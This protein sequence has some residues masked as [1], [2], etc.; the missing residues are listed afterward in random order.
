MPITEGGYFVPPGLQEAHEL[1]ELIDD[2]DL[3]L[4][5]AGYPEFNLDSYLEGHLT[6]VLFGAA[7]R[8]F[9]VAQ[10]IVYHFIYDLN[11]FGWL[12][13]RMLTAQ[14][15]TGWRAAGSPRWCWRSGSNPNR[16]WLHFPTDVVAMSR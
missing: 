10:M 13:V 9:A 6:P 14:P 12:T 15:W 4:I 3:E 8:G 11:Y 16:S 1:P 2:E 5:A 7:L